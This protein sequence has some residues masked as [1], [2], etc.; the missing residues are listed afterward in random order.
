M[1]ANDLILLDKILT[2]L[3]EQSIRKVSTG[4]VF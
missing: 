3:K 2:D 4:G 1:A